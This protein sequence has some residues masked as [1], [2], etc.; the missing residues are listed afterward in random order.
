MSHNNNI[1]KPKKKSLNIYSYY[2]N[3]ICD[4]DLKNIQ[5]TSL[6]I[7]CII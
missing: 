3:K 4:I 6:K 1:Q 5:F 2:Y 7:P